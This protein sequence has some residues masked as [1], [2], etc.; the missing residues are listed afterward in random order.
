MCPV[1]DGSGRSDET[2]SDGKRHGV[3]NSEVLMAE[4]YDEGVVSQVIRPAAI[5][6]EEAARAVLVEL[7]LRDVQNGGVWQSEPQLWSLYD[8]PWHG[9][10]NPAGAELIGSIQVAYGTPTKYE[11]TIYRVTVTRFG[12]ENGWTVDSLTDAALEFGGLT[13]AE[14]P[15]ATLMAPPKPF[16]Y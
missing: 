8:R 9:Y 4:A 7:A 6:P 16:T 12:T 15:R 10:D 2:D 13:L 3:D 5:V 11:I 1:A 14:C